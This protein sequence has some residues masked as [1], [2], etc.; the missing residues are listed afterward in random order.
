MSE[1]RR[2]VRE[3]V[4]LWSRVKDQLVLSERTTESHHVSFRFSTD[5]QQKELQRA[6]KEEKALRGEGRLEEMHRIIGPKSQVC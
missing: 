3:A 6:Q 1:A 5:R 2:S 4:K